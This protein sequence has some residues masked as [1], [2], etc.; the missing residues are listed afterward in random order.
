MAL[1]FLI[2]GAFL[3]Y[4]ATRLSMRGLDG[5]PGPGVLP[6]GLALLMVALALRLLLSSW[7]QRLKFGNLRRIGIMVAVVGVYTAVLDKLGFVVA[8]SI[9]MV[10]LLVTFNERYRLPLAALGVA[11]TVLTYQLF[12]GILKVQLPP[13]PWGLLR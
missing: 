12:F 11:G 8:T 7:H 13:D 10:L 9:M 4:Q 1:A 2:L 5:G 6:T 3:L